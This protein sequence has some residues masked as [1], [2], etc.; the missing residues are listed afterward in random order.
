MEDDWHIVNT[1]EKKQQ[2]AQQRKDTQQK[3]KKVKQQE[4]EKEDEKKKQEHEAFLRQYVYAKG[5]VETESATMFDSLRDG[6][7]KSKLLQND[8]V[9]ADDFIED[10]EINSPDA[11]S[12]EREIIDDDDDPL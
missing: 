5:P 3:E 11:S 12:S 4:K 10:E 8:M 2:K 7:F 6:Q 1:K 9:S